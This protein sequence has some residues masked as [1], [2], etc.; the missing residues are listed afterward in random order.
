MKRG[1][2][3]EETGERTKPPECG[4]IMPLVSGVPSTSQTTQPYRV[5][6][7]FDE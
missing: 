5:L 6:S 4:T 3:K 1:E 2:E 7:L